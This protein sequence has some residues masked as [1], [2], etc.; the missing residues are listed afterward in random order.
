MKGI[1]TSQ[2]EMMICVL[3][4][5]KHNLIIGIRPFFSSSLLCKGYAVVL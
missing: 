4:D 5:A 3:Q 1:S 2:C